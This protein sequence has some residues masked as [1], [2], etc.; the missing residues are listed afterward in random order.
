M[1]N[2]KLFTLGGLALL[3]GVSYASACELKLDALK[4]ASFK[5]ITERLEDMSKDVG[6]GSPD[7]P[8]VIEYGD[9]F[10]VE[11]KV[12]SI[13]NH[14]NYPASP[15]K[16]ETESEIDTKTVGYQQISYRMSATDRYGQT[17]KK[18]KSVLYL[19]RDTKAPVIKL[20]GE[21]DTI[22]DDQ[23]F[24]LSSII[25]SVK[26]PVDG[27][28]EKVKKLKDGEPGYAV[29][30]DYKKG[31]SAGDYTYTVKAQDQH[32]NTVEKSYTIH[33]KARPVV[34]APAK[35]YSSY[36]EG[37][38]GGSSY[39]A[40]AQ[41]PSY[42]SDRI[43]IG[44]YSAYLSPE[45]DQYHTDLPDTAVYY[46]YNG[47]YLVGDHAYQGFNAIRWNSTG[48]FMGRPI[49][50][51]Q[52]YMGDKREDGQVYLEDGRCYYDVAGA[53]ICMFTCVGERRA[54]TYWVF[55]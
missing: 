17:V 31:V 30:T 54:V 18:E 8:V 41:P 4:S 1:K 24:D 52:E 48:V 43:Y 38:S 55:C 35:S 20:S 12:S 22:F 47:L 10:S 7:N 14:Y 36:N 2:K 19:V 25:K 51:T 46:Y 49:V 11:N 32:G 16:L 50:K 42:S 23:A 34:Q 27:K 9:F 3:I 53:D 45:F 29:E 39:S 21:E 37:Y 6:Y 40:P 26:D 5:N 15:T 44:G 13:Q 28:I 33:V